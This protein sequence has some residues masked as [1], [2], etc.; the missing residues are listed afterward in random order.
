MPKTPSCLFGSRPRQLRDILRHEV[1]RRSGVV[2]L[3]KLELAL[4]IL[5]VCLQRR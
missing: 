1:T 5:V 3:L 4:V 2:R